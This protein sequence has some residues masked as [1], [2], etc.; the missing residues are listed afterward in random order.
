MRPVPFDPASVPGQLAAGTDELIDELVDLTEVLREL[1]E[2][3]E[4]ILEPEGERVRISAAASHSSMRRR[5][6]WIAASL[7]P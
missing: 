4:R 2:M 3:T 6:S 1:P 7:M 5:A